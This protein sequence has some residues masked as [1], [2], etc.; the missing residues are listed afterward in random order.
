MKLNRNDVLDP[1]EYDFRHDVRGIAVVISNENFN[2]DCGSS[3]ESSEYAEAELRK[4]NEM[5]SG[6]GFIVMLF[7]DLTAQQ[8]YEVIQTGINTFLVSWYCLLLDSL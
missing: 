3:T 8:M 7:K 1:R 6:L 5:F 4:M 2:F